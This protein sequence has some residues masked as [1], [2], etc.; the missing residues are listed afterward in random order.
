M[1]TIWPQYW[2]SLWIIF[3]L[4][5]GSTIGIFTFHNTNVNYLI[6]IHLPP[7][8]MSPYSDTT[9]TH[10]HTFLPAD[11]LSPQTYSW[12]QQP[13]ITPAFLH[14]RS[15]NY[16]ISFPI[17]PIY[18]KESPT[19]RDAQKPL[20]SVRLLLQSTIVWDLTTREIYR[21]KLSHKA[22]VVFPMHPI[23]TSKQMQR[24]SGAQKNSTYNTI[25][26][27]ILNS[28]SQWYVYEF[29]AECFGKGMLHI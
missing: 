7:A 26:R 9:P 10:P 14:T 23:T 2:A 29:T 13:K 3:T 8:D 5:D 28:Y 19:V 12:S 11:Q 24:K 4:L 20:E 16:I 15:P 6:S 21:Q 18:W 27:C 17:Y 1:S 22:T 25:T